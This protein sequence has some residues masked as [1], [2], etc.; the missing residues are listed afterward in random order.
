VPLNCRRAHANASGKPTSLSIAEDGGADDS[1]CGCYRYRLWRRWD[2]D[3]PT[4][5][6]VML[7]PSTAEPTTDDQTLQRCVAFA[8]RWGA[9]AVTVCNLYAWR[10]NNPRHL[11]HAKPWMVGDRN[12]E[13]ICAAAQATDRIVAAWG[14]RPDARDTRP[15]EVFDLL[16]ENDRTVW[17]LALTQHGQPRHPTRVHWDIEPEIFSGPPQPQPPTTQT[18]PPRRSRPA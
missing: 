1:P 5:L 2:P 16:V 8:R 18:R 10:T 4:V 11:R 13:V 3:R 14:A 6:F 9:G 7:Q 17:A 15:T 12:N